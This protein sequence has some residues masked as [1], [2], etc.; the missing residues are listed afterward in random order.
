MSYQGDF[1][2]NG[3][4]VVR[5]PK[6]KPSSRKS[7]NYSLS[8]A[9]DLLYKDGS[10]ETFAKTNELRFHIRLIPNDTGKPAKQRILEQMELSSRGATRWVTVPMIIED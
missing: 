5:D 1:Y 10:V 9:P 8:Q 7:D 3:K 2:T 6:P 4:P